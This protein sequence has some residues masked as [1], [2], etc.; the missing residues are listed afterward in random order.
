[1][2]KKESLE[3]LSKNQIIKIASPEALALSGFDRRLA[4]TQFFISA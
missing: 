4:G 1:M 3:R 2:A